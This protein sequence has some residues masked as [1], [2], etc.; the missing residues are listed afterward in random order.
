MSRLAGRAYHS[1]KGATEDF[2][3]GFSWPCLFGGFMWFFSKGMW[4][5]GVIALILTIGTFG[6]AW[7]I[8]PFFANGLYAKAFLQKGHFDEN[9]WR[10][11]EPAVPTGAVEPRPQRQ[12]DVSPFAD[13]AG[14]TMR[15]PFCAMIIKSES[16]ACPCCGR[17]LSQ[18]MKLNIAYAVIAGICLLG[19]FALVSKVDESKI[20][21]AAKPAVPWE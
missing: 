20:E 12:Q 3:E 4:G 16:T 19:L 15:C 14:T 21:E 1:I 9:N 18:S 6:I 11:W 8:F 5:W 17:N 2:W 7:L 10:E 13:K